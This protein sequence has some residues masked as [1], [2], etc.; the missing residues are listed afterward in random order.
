MGEKIAIVDY[1]LGNL[2]SIRMACEVVGLEAVVT[3]RAQDLFSADAVI[4]PGVGAFGD[5]MGALRRLDLVAVIHDIAA[6][7]KPLFGICLGFQLFMTESEEF[8]AH[9]GL[10]LVE[11]RVRSL[12]TPT[13]SRKRLK[14]PNVGWSQLRRAPERDWEGTP[15]SG[16]AEKTHMYFVH[17]YIVEPAD[18]ALILSTTR[19]GNVEFCSSLQA[20]AVFGCQFH[21]ERSGPEGLSIYRN[22]RTQLKARMTEGVRH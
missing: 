9:R 21:P 1:G 13:E 4:L 7:K 3:L 14:V 12:G 16:L 20:D 11:G 10:G 6:Q 18:P 15:L 2:F 17:S 5:A 19:Y 22:L 8:G